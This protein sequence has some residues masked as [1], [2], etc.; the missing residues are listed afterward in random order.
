MKNE[1]LQLYLAEVLKHKKKYL[2]ELDELRE[3]LLADNFKSRDYLATERLLQIFTELCIGLAKHC[4]KKA[5]G[6]S[7]TDAYQTFSL[8]KEHGLISSDQLMQW[9]KII[10]LRNGLVHDYLN[11]D[12]LI[13][14]HIIRQ[15]QYLQLDVFSSKAVDILQKAD[16]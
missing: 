12:L 1:G 3:D 15:R 14:E 7:A 16:V 4:L 13:I 5:Q 8:L 6:H 9:K 11:I 2:T 10:G